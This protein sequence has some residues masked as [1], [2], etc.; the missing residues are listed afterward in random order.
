MMMCDSEIWVR[1]DKLSLRNQLMITISALMAQGL[2]PKV[3]AHL[4]LGKEHGLKKTL[5]FGLLQL[6]FREKIHQMNS[7]NPLLM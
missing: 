1:E 4:I 3:K 2:Y 6:K 7:L 5:I